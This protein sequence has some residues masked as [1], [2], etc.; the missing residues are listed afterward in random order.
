MVNLT[1]AIILILILS[2]CSNEK[3]PVH[4]EIMMNGHLV[5]CEL[6]ERKDY[7]ITLKECSLVEDNKHL[8]IHNIE[9]ATNFLIVPKD[10]IF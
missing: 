2:R 8:A 7:G 9:Q 1:R 3:P 4:Y 10:A 5:V 6:A